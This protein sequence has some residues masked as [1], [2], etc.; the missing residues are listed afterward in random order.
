MALFGHLA[1]PY[2]QARKETAY[3]R[4]T[5]EIPHTAE[6][7]TAFLPKMRGIELDETDI[8][9]EN[10]DILFREPAE[11]SPCT[12]PPMPVESGTTVSAMEGPDSVSYVFKRGLK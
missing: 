12:E 7:Q 9:T 2:Q 8:P 11:H 6:E 1:Q 10:L 3:G 5:E 4:N